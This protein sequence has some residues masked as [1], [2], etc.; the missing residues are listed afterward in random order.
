MKA[1]A[2]AF[3]GLANTTDHTRALGNMPPAEFAMK[4]TLETQAT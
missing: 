1:A 2:L 4:S 3:L